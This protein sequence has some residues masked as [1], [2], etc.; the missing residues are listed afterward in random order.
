MFLKKIYY[1]AK[2]LYDSIAA[3]KNIFKADEEVFKH[4]L[5]KFEFEKL[6]EIIQDDLSNY[7]ANL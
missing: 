3:R 4:L 7:S 5:T 1:E 6:F 2:V